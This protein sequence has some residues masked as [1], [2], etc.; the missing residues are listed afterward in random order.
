MMQNENAGRDR[1]KSID[2]LNEAIGDLIALGLTD[3]REK[4]PEVAQNIADKLNSGEL[5][6]EVLVKWPYIEIHAFIE[7]ITGDTD[8][9]CLFALEVP[10]DANH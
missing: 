2:K 5:Q 4:N 3:A 10:K 9:Q 8:P 6:F 7:D 1:Q